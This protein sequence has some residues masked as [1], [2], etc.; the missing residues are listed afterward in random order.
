MTFGMMLK[1]SKTIKHA[2][3]VANT[4]TMHAYSLCI[5]CS[6][7]QNNNY[8]TNPTGPPANIVLVKNV[9]SFIG[10]R[11]AIMFVKDG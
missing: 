11:L 8:N 5:H 10:I 2:L 6:N 4:T 7:K 9:L 3:L 1:G